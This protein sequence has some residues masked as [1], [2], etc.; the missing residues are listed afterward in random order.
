M[1]RGFFFRMT[2]PFHLLLRQILPK[3]AVVCI[4]AGCENTDDT[5][6]TAHFA[7]SYDVD[8]NDMDKSD[9]LFAEASALGSLENNDMV[10]ISG[11]AVSLQD[12]NL[13][14]SH[15]DSGDMNR[16][17]LT[18]RDGRF[19]GIF[20]ILGSG[21]R[22]WEDI[23]IGKGPESDI[24]YLY[25]ADIG[26][27]NAQYDEINLYRF[28]EPD[29]TTADTSAQWTDVNP[30]LVERFPV[31]YPDGARDAETLLLDPWTL[32]LFVISK[33]EF[34]AR[35]YRLAYPYS[36]EESRTFEFYGTLPISYLTAGDISA[37]GKQIVLKTKERV[38]LWSREEGESLADAFLRQ[39]QRLPYLPEPQGE[40]I[41]FSPEDSGYYTLSEKATSSLLPVVY[42][43]EKLSK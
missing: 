29:I 26:D 23:A 37:D 2:Q 21:N 8:L 27:N 35:I 33:R 11:I 32:D 36:H 12:P 18:R 6:S 14:W 42:F 31:K 9:S 17:F 39:P 24:N 34:P 13:I 10:E 3:I 28:P 30:D 22:D 7:A 38:W 25:I 4:C 41:A 19:Q 16:V 5:P 20:R 40:A 15:N 1:H 43:Y